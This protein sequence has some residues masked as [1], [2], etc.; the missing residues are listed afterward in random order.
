M[1]VNYPFRTNRC[2][3][4][5]SDEHRTWRCQLRFGHPGEHVNF[6]GYLYWD[7]EATDP[8]MERMPEIWRAQEAVDAQKDR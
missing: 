6:T 4:T 3:A 2:R 8:L 7:G 5:R 1:T